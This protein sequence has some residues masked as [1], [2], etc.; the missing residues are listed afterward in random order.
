[1]LQ[2]SIDAASLLQSKSVDL[3]FEVK[4]EITVG[5]EFVHL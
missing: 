4:E 2:N 5:K 3:E 1:M